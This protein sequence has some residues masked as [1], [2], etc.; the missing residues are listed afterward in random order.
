MSLTNVAGQ[1]L[2]LKLGGSVGQDDTLPEDVAELQRAGA[3]VVIVHGGGPLITAWLGRAGIATRFVNG[4]RFTDDASLEVVR[5]VLGGLVNGEVVSR[6]GAAG[7]RAIGL[8]GADDG[9]LRARVKDAE[10]GRVG[11]VFA[12]NRGP[13][14][15]LLDAGYIAVIAPVALDEQGEFLNVNAD[16]VAGEVAVA[17]DA[18]RLVFLTDVP[19]VLREDA[20]LARLTPDEAGQLAE[21]GIVT[22]G[23]VPKV[24]AC[25]RAASGRR[26]AQIVDGRVPHVVVRALQGEPVGTTIAEGAAS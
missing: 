10:L 26:T 19:G 4:L 9:L 12:V 15:L 24:E 8:T 6:I 18:D 2:V 1:T 17:L 25:L 14:D 3:R 20:V 22:G 11:E 7:G 5:M 23:F 16:T 13:V 21:Q